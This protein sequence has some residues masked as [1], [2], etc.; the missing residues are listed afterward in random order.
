MIQAGKEHGD[1]S[2]TQPSSRPRRVAR[3]CGFDNIPIVAPVVSRAKH[4]QRCHH[5]QDISELSSSP[6]SLIA[7]PHFDRAPTRAI[8]GSFKSNAR[9]LRSCIGW[10]LPHGIYRCIERYFYREYESK[11]TRQSTFRAYLRYEGSSGAFFVRSRER[12]ALS[13]YLLSTLWRRR[14]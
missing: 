13:V 8:F 1:E 3:E 5:H 11:P 10:W 6:V 9:G 12:H 7:V 2:P 14:P 4:E